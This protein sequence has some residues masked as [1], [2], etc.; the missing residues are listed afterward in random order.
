MKKKEFIPVSLE[1]TQIGDTVCINDAE[2][3]TPYVVLDKGTP[4]ILLEDIN[5]HFA[6]LYRPTSNLFKLV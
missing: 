1:E 6:H 4:F 2:D 3:A 5:T